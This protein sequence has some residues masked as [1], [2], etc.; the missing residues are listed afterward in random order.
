M[1]YYLIINDSFGIRKLKKEFNKIMKPFKKKIKKEKEIT[2]KDTE[3]MFKIITSLF[4]K[5]QLINN[6]IL[7]AKGITEKKKILLLAKLYSLE[8]KILEF[9]DYVKIYDNQLI[10]YQTVNERPPLDADMIKKK[11][12]EKK[13]KVKNKDYMNDH[14][15]LYKEG[16]EK[17]R[18]IYSEEEIIVKGDNKNE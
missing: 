10:E 6:S 9:K 8:K 14:K 4:E 16:F 5:S 15:G 11:N 1:I 18:R 2:L 3:E 13:I 17:D 12:Y 7:N